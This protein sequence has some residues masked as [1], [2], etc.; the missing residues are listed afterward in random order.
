MRQ[1]MF[2]TLL[3]LLCAHACPSKWFQ[4]LALAKYWYNTSYHSTLYKTPFVVLYGDE[5]R[6]FGIFD[7]DVCLQMRSQPMPR[8]QEENMSLAKGN[9]T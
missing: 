1:S 4:W 3:V 5:P 6:H 8:R 2:R 9:P 7:L